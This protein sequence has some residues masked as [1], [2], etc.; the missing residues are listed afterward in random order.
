MRRLGKI[1][2][3]VRLA[4]PTESFSNSIICR[5]GSAFSRHDAS[6]FCETIAPWGNQRAQ[7]MPGARCKSVRR[8][9][10]DRS[11]APPRTQVPTLAM[12]QIQRREGKGP[13]LTDAAHLTFS[14]RLVRVFGRYVVIR[15]CST[16]LSGFLCGGGVIK[17]SLARDLSL[18]G[19]RMQCSS[20]CRALSSR[21]ARETALKQEAG[22]R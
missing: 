9:G 19:D 3:A 16:A 11:K 2:D 18:T 12:R 8:K 22:V 14:R 7:G 10:W 15:T 17:T 1:Y 21:I 20:A 4:H 6:E 5:R 13:C